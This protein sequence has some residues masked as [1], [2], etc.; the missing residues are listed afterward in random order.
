VSRVSTRGILLAI[1]VV[2]VTGVCVG[3][4]FWQLDRLEQRRRFN[5]DVAAA[6]ELPPLDLDAGGLEAILRDPD[7]HLFR[8][9]IARGTYASQGELILRGRSHNGRPGVHLVTPLQM[10]TGTILVNRGWLPSPDAATVDPRGYRLV[11]QQS[12]TGSL[13][14]VPDAANSTPLIVDLGDTTIRTYRRLDHATVASALD[15]PLPRLYLQL[16]PDSTAQSALPVAVPLPEMDEGPHLGYAIQWFSFAA[17]ALFGF[18]F[19]AISRLRRPGSV[20]DPTSR[21][22]RR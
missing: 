21:L 4:G 22:S 7:A 13:Q 5:A 19:V 1:A 8:R 14:E 2:L 6:A 20:S 12:L 10:R 9:A 17:I 3:L 18:L 11:G 16:L 15:R